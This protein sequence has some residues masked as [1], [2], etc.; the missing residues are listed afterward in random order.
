MRIVYLNPSGQLGGAEI[1]LLDLLSSLRAARPDYALHLIAGADG[2]LLARAERLGVT[3]LALP[4]PAAL[5]RLGDAGLKSG[6]DGAQVSRT[7]LLKKLF[8]A[9]SPVFKYTGELRRALRQARPDIIHTN[10]FKMHVLGLRA[11]PS[12][13]TPVIWHVRDYVGARPLMARLLRWHAGSC[14]AV[15]TNSE[16]VAG[17]VRAVCGDDLKVYPVLDAIDLER[18]SPSG[19]KLDLDALAG[20][21]E[22]AGGTLRVGLLATMAR[23][24]GHTTF[25]NALALLPPE[26]KVRGYIIGGA[27]YQTDGS[28]H[29]LDELRAE[30]ARLGLADKVGFTDYVEDAASA[31]RA[32]DIVVHASTQPEPFGLVIAEAMACSRA[33]VAS[34][35]GGAAEIITAGAD[36]LG[37]KPGDAESLAQ[38]LMQLLADAGL[39]ERLG[40]NG[41]LTAERRFDRARLATQLMPIYD[42]TLSSKN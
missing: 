12:K 32:L 22:A 14:A 31:M 1:A 20:L 3:A 23:W 7:G 24:K 41:R 17:D 27:L 18:F 15:V 6:I 11:R 30:A 40:H 25:L 37:H 21:P 5:A 33:L 35:A 36:A 29:S 28:Q 2:P 34:Q 39:R 38:C 13:E 8:D 42:R 9:G 16:S 26:S 19:K 10:G 4:F